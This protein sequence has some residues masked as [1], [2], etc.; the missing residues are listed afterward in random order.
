MTERQ[1]LQVLY[2]QTRNRRLSSEFVE[3]CWQAGYEYAKCQQVVDIHD[4]EIPDSPV[5]VTPAIQ[6][7]IDTVVL[8]GVQTALDNVRKR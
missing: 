4:I 3:Q 7:G 6:E 2:V 5:K 1:L 8:D